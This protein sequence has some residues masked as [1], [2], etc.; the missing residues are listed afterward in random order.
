MIDS[1]SRSSGLTL[2]SDR[3]C[4]GDF[5]AGIRLSAAVALPNA[6]VRGAPDSAAERAHLRDCPVAIIIVCG[7]RAETVD[8]GCGNGGSAPSKSG[9]L[10]RRSIGQETCVW[11][12]RSCNGWLA[13]CRPCRGTSFC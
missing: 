10:V 4:E 8:P 7:E 5:T 11:E 6:C 9:F 1:H 12:L 3:Y 13:R 2:P